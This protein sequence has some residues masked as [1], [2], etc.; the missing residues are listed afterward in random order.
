MPTAGH[1]NIKIAHEV[2]FVLRIFLRNVARGR[3]ASVM[4]D[5]DFVL[6][7]YAL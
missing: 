7:K 2:M 3:R 4:P 1:V 5:D 6:A